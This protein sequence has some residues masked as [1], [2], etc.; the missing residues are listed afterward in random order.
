MFCLNLLFSYVLMSYPIHQIIEN[1]LYGDQP[2][3]T[4]VSMLMN[5]NR[6]VTV[7]ITVFICLLLGSKGDKF[8]SLVGAL[9]CTPCAFTL[10]AW[11]HLRACSESE[12]PKQ[13]KR[14]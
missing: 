13:T 4:R 8:V 10:P 5:C 1:K 3:T 12:D 11:Y 2:I 6:A 7:A 14:T 9:T